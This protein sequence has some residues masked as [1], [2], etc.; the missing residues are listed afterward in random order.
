MSASKDLADAKSTKIWIKQ[1][2][3]LSNLLK[4]LKLTTWKRTG[5]PY[6]STKFLT[7][8]GSWKL[9]FWI[10]FWYIF[11]EIKNN[12]W[13]FSPSWPYLHNKTKY[14]KSLHRHFFKSTR[15]LT[16]GLFVTLLS[17]L[18]WAERE[19]HV[20]VCTGLQPSPDWEIPDTRISVWD[21]LRGSRGWEE[22]QDAARASHSL[23][24]TEPRTLLDVTTRDYDNTRA[25][26][27]A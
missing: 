27:A 13:H 10:V 24:L 6:H 1:V 4:T 5:K 14:E 19:R 2:Y 11:W 25:M 22:T 16:P 26:T 17:R 7:F 20:H 21:L 18:V 3:T 9:L 15:S 12:V 8:H 23:L